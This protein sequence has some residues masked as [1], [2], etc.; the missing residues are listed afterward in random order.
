MF[1]CHYSHSLG[2]KL[3]LDEACSVHKEGAI[4]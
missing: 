1:V 4:L 3:G 2:G